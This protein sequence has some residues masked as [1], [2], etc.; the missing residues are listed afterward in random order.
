MTRWYYATDNRQRLGPVTSQELRRLAGSGEIGP[1]CMVA[2]EGSNKWVPANKV[3][4]LFADT[5]AARVWTHK[6]ALI[7]LGVAGA[8]LLGLLLIG[9]PAVVWV[10]QLGLPRNNPSLAAWMESER[11]YRAAHPPPVFIG[12][13]LEYARM[14]QAA[15]LTEPRT[16]RFVVRAMLVSGGSGGPIQIRV[17]DR[18]MSI[19]AGVTYYRALDKPLGVLEDGKPHLVLADLAYV[20]EDNILVVLPVREK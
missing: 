9:V 11:A 15:V 3:R 8:V 4:G 20:D 19:L 14:L 7:I 12:S 2:R 18:S 6:K 5:A 10:S 1:A 17:E 13:S 16:Q